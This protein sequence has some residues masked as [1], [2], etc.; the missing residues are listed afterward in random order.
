MLGK[1]ATISFAVI[2]ITLSITRSVDAKIT[3][4][5]LPDDKLLDGH[6]DWK[7]KFEDPKKYEKGD[8]AVRAYV[9]DNHPDNKWNKATKKNQI[10]IYNFDTRADQ[11]DAGLHALLFHVKY[12]KESGT[13]NPTAAE[14]R[15]HDW[16]AEQVGS[17]V[18][19]T[20]VSSKIIQKIIKTY[21]ENANYGHVPTKLFNSDV[22]FWLKVATDKI[23]DLDDDYDPDG[24]NFDPNAPDCTFVQCAEAKTWSTYHRLEVLV[25]PYSCADASDCKFSN[26]VSGRGELEVTSVDSTGGAYTLSNDLRYYAKD[27]SYLTTYSISHEIKVIVYVG[28]KNTTIG[29]RTGTDSITLSGKAIVCDA[30]C[31][32]TNCGTFSITGIAK[33]ATFET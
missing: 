15:F 12:Q 9:N 29:P 11:R 1:L 23:C 7:L 24:I 8:K 32:G 6:E 20:N 13:Y 19:S 26:H 17:L 31:R 18:M 3:E 14:K 21:N 22:D 25:E 33:A 2:T 4:E 10:K 28:E 5:K 30:E 27:C 16:A